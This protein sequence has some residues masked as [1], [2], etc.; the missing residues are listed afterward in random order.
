MPAAAARAHKPLAPIEN[1]RL[2]TVSPR[3]LRR[4]G[5]DLTAARPTRYD[6]PDP[7]LGGVPERHRRPAIGVHFRGR[8]TPGGV[9][10]FVGFS[11]FARPFLLAGSPL[12]ARFPMVCAIDLN[13]LTAAA[14]PATGLPRWARQD[15]Q[16]HQR[17]KRRC[18]TDADPKPFQASAPSPHNSG[19]ALP[20]APATTPTK[21]R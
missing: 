18:R 14:M 11:V 12:G 4:V 19:V 6:Q 15:D 8:L 5:L 9:P 16:T 1:C 2:G 10:T 3:H 13:E 7:G 20:I 21:L 17:H